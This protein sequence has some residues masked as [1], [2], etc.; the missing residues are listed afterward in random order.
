MKLS[1]KARIFAGFSLLLL[2]LAISTGVSSVLIGRIDTQ[3]D[4]YSGAQGH[5]ALAKDIDLTMTK[6]R[7]RVNQ[8][9]RSINPAFAKQ[10]DELLAED[11][12][13][14]AKAAGNV[15]SEEERKI[16][17]QMDTALKAY[18]ASWGVVQQIYADEAKLHA[19]KL[20]KP[21][22]EIAVSLS[23]IRN[24]ALAANEI[25]A[26]A[27]VAEARDEFTSAAFAA[28]RYRTTLDKAALTAVE[29]GITNAKMKLEAAASQLR[30]ASLLEG[31]QKLV[32][33]LGTWREAFAEAAKIA[34]TRVARLDSWTRNEGEAM[35]V[36]S[37]AL[38][39]L[40][41]QDASG[42]QAELLRT[43][44]SS[45]LT[46]YVSAGII[47]AVGVLI[48]LLLARTIT[49]PLA[50]LTQ[51]MTRLAQGDRT[52]TVPDTD[53]SDEIGQMAKA[54]D[55]FRQNLTETDRMR[56]EQETAK[57]Q[58][59]NERRAQMLK[60]A[61]EFEAAVG[62]IV[63]TVSTAASGMESAAQGLSTTAET[64][65]K[66]ATTVAA[67][68]EE[69]S[70][71]VQTVATAGEELSSSISEI[72]RQVTQSTRIAGQAVEQAN[73]T[74]AQV[75]GLA[76]AAQKIGEV[77]SLINDIAAQT[78]LLALNATIE[79]AR[80]GEAGKGFAVVA[81]EVKSLANQT[82]KATEEIGQ[83]IAGIQGATKDSVDAIKLIGKTIG[84]VNEIAT[85][86]ASAVE[87]QSAATQEIARNVQQAAK[88]TQDVSSNIA[89]VTEAATQTGTA[90]TQVLSSA[91]DLAKQS[92]LLRVQVDKFLARV[93]AA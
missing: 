9:L 15:K 33:A 49:G 42:I 62:G 37:A 2:M 83:Q 24:G 76:D 54:T 30:D 3:S 18:I 40:T 58:L 20:D 75:Q 80:A 48:S 7:V 26:A 11:V 19:E 87:E 66:Q 50:R 69:A 61:E 79:A 27:A 78:N 43:I 35:A 53:R 68:S 57:A 74:D 67:A 29:T 73:K 14:V 59:E 77:V 17:G 47:F 90:A 23:T 28:G 52:V 22:R 92:E 60:M 64:A 21:G 1:I 72:G 63:K 71:N 51:V 31:V 4:L 56:A 85:T 46:L 38:M 89:G 70:S 13:L 44:R 36:A 91:R 39:K 25:A 32:P 6:V 16:I 88:G 45:D 55:T 65:S 41:E 12:A 34:D 86:I 82:A 84:E 10:A 93:R 5:A 8:W 81:S